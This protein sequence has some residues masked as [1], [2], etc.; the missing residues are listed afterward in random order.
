[1]HTADM[2]VH[3]DAQTTCGQPPYYMPL[4]ACWSVEAEK[5]KKTTCLLFDNVFFIS[6]GSVSTR[7]RSSGQFY[8]RCMQHLFMIK[9]ILKEL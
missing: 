9:T 8:Y 3:I 2:K 6:L 4:A 7:S 1:M 5:W